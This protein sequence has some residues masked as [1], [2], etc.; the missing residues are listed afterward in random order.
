M[1]NKI[2]HRDCHGGLKVHWI[3]NVAV[4]SDINGYPSLYLHVYAWFGIII[5]GCVVDK[6]TPSILCFSDSVGLIIAYL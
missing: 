5:L 3:L 6:A 4:Q 2:N 1:M